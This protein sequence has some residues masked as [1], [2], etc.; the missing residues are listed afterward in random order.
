[1]KGEYS[2]W[3]VAYLTCKPHIKSIQ[4]Q[5]YNP[6]LDKYACWNDPNKLPT[7]DTNSFKLQNTFINNGSTILYHQHVYNWKIWHVYLVRNF[8]N[9]AKNI[10]PLFPIVANIQPFSLYKEHVQQPITWVWLWKVSQP[11]SDLLLRNSK[12]NHR[13]EPLLPMVLLHLFFLV[14][15]LYTW[16]CIGSFLASFKFATIKVLFI[17]CFTHG[18]WALC[19]ILS[20]KQR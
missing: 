3:H 12:C 1:M 17:S 19:I 18:L 8:L 11:H 15:F 20:S 16:F 6:I 7:N 4:K 14:S 13:Q 5:F 9:I 2:T 10:E